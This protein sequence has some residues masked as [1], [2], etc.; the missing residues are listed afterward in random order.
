M[1]LLEEQEK[2]QACTKK[3]KR[4]LR[5]EIELSRLLSTAGMRGVECGDQVQ[6]RYYLQERREVQS[7]VFSWESVL[8]EYPL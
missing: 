6:V 5:V 4:L 7:E 2:S 8:Q 3:E 1:A